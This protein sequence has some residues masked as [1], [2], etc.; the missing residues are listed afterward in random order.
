MSFVNLF[1]GTHIVRLTAR[2]LLK[3]DRFDRENQNLLFVIVHIKYLQT[4]KWCLLNDWKIHIIWNGSNPNWIIIINKYSVVLF[5]PINFSEFLFKLKLGYV[6]FSTFRLLLKCSFNGFSHLLH[7][8]LILS[9]RVS[10]R[11]RC[12]LS[13]HKYIL[14]HLAF[15]LSIWNLSCL[16]T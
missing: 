4:F 1:Q 6:K 2:I 15:I 16:T 10:V 7:Y 5:I 9:Y 11:H 14:S 3:K 8:S 12:S 13:N